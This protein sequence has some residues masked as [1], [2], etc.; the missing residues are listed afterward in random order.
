M[1]DSVPSRVKE[2]IAGYQPDDEYHICFAWSEELGGE[3]NDPNARFRRKVFKT[4]LRDLESAPL[5]LLRDLYEAETEIARAA[6]GINDGVRDLGEALLRRGGVEF[7]DDFLV[8]KWQCFDTYMGV[9][10]T[11][12]AALS[13]R[14]VETLRQRLER[15]PESPFAELWREGEKLFSSWL[16]GGEHE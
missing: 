13:A 6:G 16:P 12:D 3:L 1:S 15:E 2:F 10:V 9:V 5:I 7:L 14:L 8:G 4:V 11:P